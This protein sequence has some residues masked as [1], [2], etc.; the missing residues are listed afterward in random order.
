M[1][2]RDLSKSYLLFSALH[3]A[4]FILAIVVIGLYGTD[5]DRA[6]KAHVYSDGK[7]VYG[8]VVG[9]LSAVTVLFYSVPSIIR[10]AFVPAWSAVLFILWIALFG[11]FGSMFIHERAAGNGDIQ[12]MKNAVWIDLTNA[13]LWLIHTV[14]GAAYWWL[15]RE[16]NSRFTG[17]ARV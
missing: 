4:Q 11:I 3:F 9:S 6:R 7:W 5:V 8:I 1:A 13:L 17:R 16:R 10:F 2:L 14:S 15:H 12:R